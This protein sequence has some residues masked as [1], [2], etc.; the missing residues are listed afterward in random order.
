MRQT[1]G[2]I[3]CPR[4]G[5]LIGVNESRCPFCNAWRPGLFGWAPGLHR[6]VGQRV[7]LVSLIIS[8]CSVLYVVSLLLQPEAILQPRGILSML[9]PGPRALWQLG[10]TGGIAWASGWWW[11]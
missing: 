10:M 1:S 11:T 8:S 5:K 6:F 2:A 7:D 3:V 4:C 9:A